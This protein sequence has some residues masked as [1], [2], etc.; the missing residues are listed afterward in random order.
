MIFLDRLEQKVESLQIENKKLQK[1]NKNLKKENSGINSRLT[2]IEKRNAIQNPYSGS[3]P[4]TMDEN[5]EEIQNYTHRIHDTQEHTI[6][7][8][9]DIAME[10]YNYKRLLI[11]NTSMITFT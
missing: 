8:V 5:N 1:E 6:Q 11:R 7:M 10:N 3:K 9:D 4:Q 2:T